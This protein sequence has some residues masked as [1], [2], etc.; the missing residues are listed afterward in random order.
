MRP[1]A[2]LQHRVMHAL[3]EAPNVDDTAV[4]VTVHHGVV[5]LTGIVASYAAKDAAGSV[6]HDVPGV[7]DLA[8]DLEVRPDWQRRP[9]D[10]DIA[11]AVRIALAGAP[12]RHEQIRSTIAGR[13]HVKL[14]GLVTTPTERALA[15]TAVKR[16]DGVEIVTNL[17]EIANH[18]RGVS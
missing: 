14:D 18:A 4:G 5:T 15:E 8:N 2:D 10:T 3:M 6:A 16:V 13:G 9:S 17:I 7:L 11:E 12:V 1:D